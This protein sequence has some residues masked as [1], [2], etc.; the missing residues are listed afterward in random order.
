M[1]G[2]RRGYG[3]IRTGISQ[4]L[5][6]VLSGNANTGTH[7]THSPSANRH[8]LQRGQGTNTSHGAS[9]ASDTGAE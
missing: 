8:L 6:D 7:G 1:L 9:A 5:I 2:D 3:E 4:S